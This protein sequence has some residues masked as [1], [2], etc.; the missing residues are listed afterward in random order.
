MLF[1][2]AGLLGGLAIG[3]GL[4]FGAEALDHSI[5]SAEEL[6]SLLGYP[7]LISL[8]DFAALPREEKIGRAFSRG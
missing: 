8:P 6:S 5:K 7:V 4:A 3:L 2:L 1:S